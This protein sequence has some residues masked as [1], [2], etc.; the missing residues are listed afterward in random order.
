MILRASGLVHW[1]GETVYGCRSGPGDGLGGMGTLRR[2]GAGWTGTYP[3]GEHPG[4]RG[5]GGHCGRRLNA[6][7]EAV[8]ELLDDV[9]ANPDAAGPDKSGKLYGVPMYLK[10]LGSGLAGGARI[11]V[12]VHQGRAH[13]RHRPRGRDF[14]RAGLVPL[15]RST[16][17]DWHDLRPATDYWR[18]E[19]DAQPMEP[20]GRSGRFVGG[21]PLRWRRAWCAVHVVRWWRIDTHPRIVLRLVSLKA[22]RGRVPRPLSRNGYVNDQH[23][24]R[25]VTQRA[26]HGGGV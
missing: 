10:D 1:E 7:L 8:I 12:G 17:R 11:Q 4:D 24:R 14:L 2:R 3:A 9:R 6:K 23:R 13:R 25:C 18:G 5:T 15:G 20:G 21:R 16:T 22:S 19:G 26:R